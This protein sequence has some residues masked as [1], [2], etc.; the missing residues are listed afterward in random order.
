[1]KAALQEHLGSCWEKIDSGGFIRF[2]S[3]FRETESLMASS[4]VFLPAPK[5]RECG[6]L[7]LEHYPDLSLSF[8]LSLGPVC[9]PADAAESG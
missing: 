7:E 5:R 6:A 2:S 9:G 3:D 1:M 8:L 4:H